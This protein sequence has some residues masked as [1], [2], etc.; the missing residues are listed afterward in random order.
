M[1]GASSTRAASCGWRW[2]G[3]CRRAWG[4]AARGVHRVPGRCAGGDASASAA[5]PH[6]VRCGCVLLGWAPLAGPGARPCA[7]PGPRARGGGP[8]G[9]PG[10]TSASPQAS[11]APRGGGWARPHAALAL[12][13]RPVWSR[14][15][16]ARQGMGGA[17]R[18]PWSGAT[19]RCG[20]ASHRGRGV[21]GRWHATPGR[22]TRG[23]SGSARCRTFARL[24]SVGPRLSRR[25]PPWRLGSPTS[26]GRCTHGCHGTY[27]R[28]VGHHP[29]HVG[30]PRIC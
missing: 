16:A 4:G 10:A 21:A 12:A 26:A 5:V 29:S 6:P 7:L 14:A 30:D 17:R 9:V 8:G 1:R 3:W 15:D 13:R 27:R 20:T 24:L 28:R 25:R 19:R 23:C 2:P 11:T 18:P 22:C